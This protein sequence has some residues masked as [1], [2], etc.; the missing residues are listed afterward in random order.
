MDIG[1]ERSLIAGVCTHAPRTSHERDRLGG[2]G[3]PTAARGAM[4]L[5]HHAPQ[6]HDSNTDTGRGHGRD[7]VDGPAGL[8]L[9]LTPLGIRDAE[10]RERERSPILAG[11]GRDLVRAATQLGAG[12]DGKQLTT[13]V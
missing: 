5:A 7:Q 1:L 11:H 13:P 12:P 9:P 3:Q 8:L 10:M 4:L 6:E 2:S